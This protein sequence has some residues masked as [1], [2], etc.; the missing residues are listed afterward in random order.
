MR[1]NGFTLIGRIGSEYYFC[2]SIFQHRDDF[3]G[4]IGSIIR[5]VS[6]EEYDW[7]NEIENVKDRLYDVYCERNS[8][9]DLDTDDPDFTKWVE[10]VMHYD[11]VVNVMFDESYCCDASDAFEELG[12]EHECTDCTGGGRI[13]SNCP[14]F[15]EVFDRK[16]LVA[17]QALESGAVDADYAAKV[18]FA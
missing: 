16:A 4:A 15:D 18:V 10:D 9:Q 17:I 7:A 12:I 6:Q 3:C 8:V 13:F 1:K 14:D 5:P 2:D 11:G